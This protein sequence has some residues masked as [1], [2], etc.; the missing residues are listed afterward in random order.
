VRKTWNPNVVHDFSVA[1]VDQDHL[2]DLLLR[3]LEA[4]CPRMLQTLKAEVYSPAVAA[5]QAVLVRRGCPPP[6]VSFGFSLSDEGFGASEA[7]N[8]IFSQG[9]WLK[10]SA[11]AKIAF[12]TWRNRWRL[13]GS[14]LDIVAR[15]TVCFWVESRLTTEQEPAEFIWAPHREVLLFLPTSGA[16]PEPDTAPLKAWHP[17][18][19]PLSMFRERIERHILDQQR[20]GRSAGLVATRER[21]VDK[22]VSPQERVRWLVHNR[23]L[24]ASFADLSNTPRARGREWSATQI[25]VAVRR[26]EQELRL[27]I[28]AN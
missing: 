28:T 27:A 15:D 16:N 8:E 11:A 24:G 12:E 9:G 1:G 23:W 10:E 5:G 14:A 17:R 4:S 22:G 25:R 18:H 6:I 3:E 19:E 26:L 7:A 13:A 20:W 21:R 2:V